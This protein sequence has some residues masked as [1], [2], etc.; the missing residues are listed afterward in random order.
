MLRDNRVGLIKPMLSS[1]RANPL[2]LCTARQ[3]PSDD[4]PHALKS[5][6][7]RAESTLTEKRRSPFHAEPKH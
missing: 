1:A 4:R 2:A 7:E 6:P 3:K 5:P